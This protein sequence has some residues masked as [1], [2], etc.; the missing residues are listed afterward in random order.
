MVEWFTDYCFHLHQYTVNNMCIPVHYNV[1]DA[2]DNISLT[3]KCIRL[4]T[5]TVTCDALNRDWDN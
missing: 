5:K 3:V 2:T 1:D 4:A